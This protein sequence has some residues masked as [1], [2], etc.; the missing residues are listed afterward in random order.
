MDENLAENVAPEFRVLELETEQTA[1][2]EEFGVV[3]GSRAE[4]TGG[5]RSGG[6]DGR[7]RGHGGGGGRGGGGVFARR[8]VDFKGV[9]LER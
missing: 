7:G 6:G 4:V 5:G 1:G 3:H 9:P 2:R 8:G